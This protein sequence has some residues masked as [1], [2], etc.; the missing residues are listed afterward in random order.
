MTSDEFKAE[1]KAI[2]LS[3]K[4]FAAKG[5]WVYQSVTNA[6]SRDKITEQMVLV[7]E[8]IKRIKELESQVA[9]LK[10]LFKSQD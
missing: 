1:L 3:V 9:G 4:D 8:M 5:G 2:N 7:L 10:A 6:I